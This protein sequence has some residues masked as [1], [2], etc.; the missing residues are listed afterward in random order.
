MNYSVEIN[1][2]NN[3]FNNMK[4][5]FG[6]PPIDGKIYCKYCNECLCDE[7]FSSLEGFTDDKPVKSNEALINTKETEIIKEKLDSKKEVV[8]LI[9]MIANMFG[10]IL[11]EKDIYEI[12]ISY[13]NI[14][15]N[16]LADNRYNMVGVSN[17]DIHPK[18]KNLLT[19]NKKAEKNENG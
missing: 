8:S 1:N 14:N 18:V 2:S 11:N 13:D 17:T 9:S 19:E 15:H 7:D 5:V 3:V 10:V 16:I 6:S 4:T 12:I